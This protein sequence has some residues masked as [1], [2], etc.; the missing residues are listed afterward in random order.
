MTCFIANE[1]LAEAPH[2]I[3]MGRLLLQVYIVGPFNIQSLQLC[4][5]TIAGMIAKATWVPISFLT[6]P[7]FYFVWFVVLNIY[8]VTVAKNGVTII[9]HWGKVFTICLVF[10]TFVYCVAITC[11]AIQFYYSMTKG[12]MGFVSRENQNAISWYTQTWAMGHRVYK[13]SWNRE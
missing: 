1:L 2:S 10:F 12:F 5:S 7:F 3:Q 6:N 4:T 9:A 8:S 13:S 11:L